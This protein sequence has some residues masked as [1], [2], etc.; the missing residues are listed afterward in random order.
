[1]TRKEEILDELVTLREALQTDLDD[2]AKKSIQETI[3]ELEKEF[4]IP[5]PTIVQMLSQPQAPTPP[6]G[7]S[8]V[9]SA[10][11]SLR[12]TML[13]GAG[14]GVDS[15]EVRDLIEE[16]LKTEKVNLSELDADVLDEIRKNQKVILEIPRFGDLKIE[17]TKTDANIPYFFEVL[18]DVMAGNNVYLIGE[19]GGGKAQPL[20]SKI[21]TENGWITFADVKVGDKVFGEDGKLYE[22]NGV[23]DRGV[24]PTYKVKM[25]DGTHTETCDE[26]L[27]KIYTRNERGR[28][29]DGKVLPLKEFMTKI[30]TKK[31]YANA[32]IDINK[33]IQFKE[34]NHVISPYLMG[35]I[36]GDG[37]I[38]TRSIKITN[39]SQEIFD[40]IFVEEGLQVNDLKTTHNRCKTYSIT[41]KKQTGY[42]PYVKELDTMGLIGMKSVEKFIPKE[43]L[44][45]SIQNRTLLL[46]GLNDTDGYSDDSH[47]EFS[48][49]SYQLSED[50]CEL[51]RSLGGTAKKSSRIP[52]YTHKGEKKEGAINYRIHC[53]FP[54][55]IQPFS[56]GYKLER[57]KKP[58]KYG[59][60]RYIDE[61]EYLGE[62]PV[63]CISVT[64]PSR[65]YIT[66]N[67]IVT[68]NTYT[69]EEVAKKLKR[70]YVIINC[71]QY[72]SPTEIL[73]GQTIEGYK[74]GKLIDAW[75][76][77]KI[78]ILDEMPRLDPNTAGLFNDA[79][80]KSSKTREAKNAL[81]NSTNPDE[82]PVE[83]ND[84]FALI[85]TGNVYPNTAPP[86]K[87][88]ANNQQDLSLLDRFSGSVY[89][90]EYSMPTDEMVS[91]FKFLY[92]MLV[93]NYY[94]YMNAIKNK[95]SKPEP[96]G[97]RTV[98]K[99]LELE[100]LAV[101]S[102]RTL[103]SFRVAFEFE[104]V[105]AIAKNEGKN[106]GVDRGKTLQK[107]FDS[108]MVA[109]Q[110][111]TV[112]IIINKTKFT[113]DFIKSKV[114]ECI[115]EII[116]GNMR[117][118]L[119]DSVAQM[120]S[121]IFKRYDDFFA[122]ETV[123]P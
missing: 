56:L 99:D 18:D 59:V 53:V 27:W 87:Y 85:A 122:P 42:N 4:A 60:K 20:T 3:D 11:A 95:Q 104:L 48:T 61:V 50:Y 97:L 58:T 117:E 103:V 17:V 38:T 108:F 66:D 21:L 63:R 76:N 41:R 116:K 45:D 68:H 102:Y 118:T 52:K 12:A 78:L 83:R 121:S 36:L 70:E 90:V 2:D 9:A 64:N 100:D 91:R 24:R 57:F 14:S 73:G 13:S 101:V 43:Y 89:K 86:K 81:I 47:F 15:K 120:T 28:K 32:F 88:K 106:V 82:P 69:A 26:H 19:A 55:E 40:K 110:K 30:K 35:L 10:L 49:S 31:G 74:N 8:M 37:S 105:R 54:D 72:T 25:N 96:K 114:D 123:N 51:V 6:Q 84:K 115:N 112:D 111:D 71:S 29:K 109:F 93:G 16:Y 33:P 67:Y 1:M 119:N 22:V 79:L 75:K 44:Y 98:L 94:E 77:G 107:A 34:R 5:D 80:A 46:Q 92:E 7:G 39:P 65:L 113:P 62:M 23:F